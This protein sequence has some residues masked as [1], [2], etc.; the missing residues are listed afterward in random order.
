MQ[1]I[2]ICLKFDPGGLEYDQDVSSKLIMK[3]PTEQF[4]GA[5]GFRL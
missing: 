2:I 4:A 5:R 3:M 1:M